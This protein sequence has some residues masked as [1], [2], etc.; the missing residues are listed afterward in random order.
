[1]TRAHYALLPDRGV[2][3]VSGEDA[4]KLLQGII[5]ND[6]DLLQKQPA[7]HTA[8]LTPQGKILFEFFVAK[9]GAGY[10]LDVAASQIADLIKRLAMYKL[11]AK[12]DIK[13]A[14]ADY[15]VIAVWGLSPQSH[16]KASGIVSFIDPRLPDLGTRI[17]AEA[18]LAA[19]IASATNAMEA[20]AADYDGHRI[21]LGVPEITKDYPPSDTFAHEANLDVLKSVSFA[22]GCFIGQ[23]VASRMEHRG[24]ARTR[25]VIVESETPLAPAGKITAGDATI[26]TIGSTAGTRAIALV[27]LD[28]ADEAQTK[29]T[30]ITAG[31]V[32]IT[33]RRPGYLESAAV[34]AR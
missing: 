20:T 29:S 7:L 25:A 15:R 34:P 2:V 32:A 27:R 31:D 5:T 22:K 11:R 1:M 10:L 16:G 14:C 13:D 12:V 28:R 8:L 9:S 3:S 23:E 26:G 24:T 19:D 4:A 6:M 17:L 30:P 33:I 21:A 18:A